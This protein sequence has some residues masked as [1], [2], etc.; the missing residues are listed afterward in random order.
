MR[1][2]TVKSTMKKRMKAIVIV[3]VKT[4][5]KRMKRVVKVTAIA[6]KRKTWTVIVKKS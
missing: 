3:I 6:K 1:K 2:R 5:T 4:I